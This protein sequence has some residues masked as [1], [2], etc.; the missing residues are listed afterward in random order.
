MKGVSASFQFMLFFVIGLSLFISMS[1]VFRLQVDVFRDDVAD[2]TRKLDSTFVSSLAV[3][4]R[5]C[6]ACD[7]T[8]LSFKFQNT[9]ANYFYVIS[10][11]SSGI[12]VTSQPGGKTFTSTVHNLASSVPMS[13]SKSSVETITLTLNKPQ[14]KLEVK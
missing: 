7:V 6:I 1:S 11:G 9:T 5:G 3:L 4:E 10:G 14:N 2:A 12:T 8:S 13:G